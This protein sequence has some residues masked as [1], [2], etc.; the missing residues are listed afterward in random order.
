MLTEKF[1]NN[2]I[3]SFWVWFYKHTFDSSSRSFASARL[4]TAIAKKTFRR[5]SYIVK[6]KFFFKNYL[7]IEYWLLTPCKLVYLVFDT[8]KKKIL[9]VFNGGFKKYISVKD[10]GWNNLQEC[11]S[12]KRNHSLTIVKWSNTVKRWSN[13]IKPE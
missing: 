10:F 1:D 4:S 13:L 7:T 3:H 12:G 11:I 8:L 6:K 5:V 2:K 9:T